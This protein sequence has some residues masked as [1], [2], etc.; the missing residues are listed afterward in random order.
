MPILLAWNPGPTTCLLVSDTP[1]V[2]GP[3]KLVGVFQPLFP[4][5][6][7][8]GVDA[9]FPLFHNVLCAVYRVVIGPA[10]PVVDFWQWWPPFLGEFGALAG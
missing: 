10:A 5:H 8:E 9:A 4:Q 1:W 6:A 3:A 7:I 2:I